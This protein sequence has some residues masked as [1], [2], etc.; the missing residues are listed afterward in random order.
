MEDGPHWQEPR[1]QRKGC[2]SVGVR[3][4]KELGELFCKL[5]SAPTY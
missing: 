1:T 4:V 3:L 2:I 5:D